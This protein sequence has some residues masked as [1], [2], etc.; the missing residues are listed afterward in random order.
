[1]SK[2]SFLFFSDVARILT[3]LLFSAASSHRSDCPVYFRNPFEHAAGF[4][5]PT[6][7]TEKLYQLTTQFR[8]DPQNLN[9]ILC[10]FLVEAPG[11]PNSVFLAELLFS[12]KD[13]SHFSR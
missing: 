7:S 11:D 2:L 9:Q 1:M 5:R 4:A 13:N 10:D 12:N 6:V 8:N 3:I